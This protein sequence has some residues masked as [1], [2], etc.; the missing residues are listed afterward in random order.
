MRHVADMTAEAFRVTV[1]VLA[2]LS[3]ADDLYQ[4]P[5]GWKDGVIATNSVQLI[6]DPLD[7]AVALA[8]AVDHC[9]ISR[10]AIRVS[11]SS[12]ASR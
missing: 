7:E 5:R 11:F 3:I 8:E 9:M 4:A 2:R 12:N 1:A 10:P 6:L